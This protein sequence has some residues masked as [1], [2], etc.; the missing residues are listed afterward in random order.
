MRHPREP[1]GG[2]GGDRALKDLPVDRLVVGQVTAPHGTDGKVRVYPLTD[3][4]DRL[5]RLR[6]VVL[7]SDAGER[8]V[9]VEGAWPYGR[10]YLMKFAG[11]DSLEAAARLRGAYLT[12]AP[13]EAVPL[14]PGC[15]YFY[16]IVGLEVIEEGGG[17][18]GTVSQVLRTG[19]NDVYVV[20]RQDAPELLIPALKAVV[21]EIDLEKGV[22]V[23][24]RLEEW[25]W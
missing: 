18:V 25:L 24:R 7:R 3:F 14:P 21:R 15:Y 22:M 10:L 20:R 9:G 16:R 6:E 2:G 4:P 11:C 8:R 5:G 17:V 19:A 23:V 13:E 12:V 1:A